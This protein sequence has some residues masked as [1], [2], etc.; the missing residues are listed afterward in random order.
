MKNNLVIISDIEHS[1]PRLTNLI[2]YL[3]NEKYTKFWITADFEFRLNKNDLPVG[4][5]KNVKIYKFKR[6]I[7]LFNVLK[8]FLKKKNKKEDKLSIR[9]QNSIS[10]LTKLF[11]SFLYPDQYIFYFNEYIKIFNKL[12]LDNNR[13]IIISSHPYPTS[14]IVGNYISRKINAKWIVDYRDLWSKNHNYPFS[15]FRKYLDFILEKKLIKRADKIIT[16][17]NQLKVIINKNFTIKSKIIYN[18]Y[19]DFKKVNLNKINFLRK[20]KINII[21]VGSIYPDFQDVDLFF[22]QSFKKPNFELHFAGNVKSSLNKLIN[23]S[24]KEYVKMIGIFNRLEINNILQKYDYMLFFDSKD[25]SGVLPLKVFEYINSRKP[26]ICVGGNNYNEIQEILREYKNSIF[27]KTYDE[28]KNFF[29][30]ILK[31]DKYT[32]INEE[33]VNKFSYQNISVELDKIL[34]SL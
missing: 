13:T 18:G 24:N 29:S 17:S 19:E 26:I 30:N 28:V 25:N 11:L 7:N 21:H 1:A 34:K 3:P 23:H 22:N 15:K 20:D 14:I 32:I 4:F 5:D 8:N 12:N 16:V 2:H 9:K 10:F 31:T 27:L 6:K 33:L